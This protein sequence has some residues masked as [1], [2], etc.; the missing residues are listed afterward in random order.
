MFQYHSGNCILI[1]YIVILCKDGHA[2]L[3]GFPAIS[4]IGCLQLFTVTN[5][6]VRTSLSI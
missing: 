4:H 5:N 1:N 6:A 3:S 2:Y